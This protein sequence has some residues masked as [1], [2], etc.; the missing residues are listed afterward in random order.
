VIEANFTLNPANFSFDSKVISA[1]KIAAV[2]EEDMERRVGSSPRITK[3]TSQ[4]V[5]VEEDSISTVQKPQQVAG[6]YAVKIKTTKHPLQIKNNPVL[7]SAARLASDNPESIHQLEEQPNGE[8][9]LRFQGEVG[10]SKCASAK[11][12]RILS[13]KLSDFNLHADPKKLVLEFKRDKVNDQLGSLLIIEDYK[14]TIIQF[15]DCYVQFDKAGRASVLKISP[16]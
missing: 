5:T 15:D 13:S 7:A 12:I 6:N 16:T 2:F 14:N 3:I 4:G 9:Y 10:I 1:G 11:V 8:I